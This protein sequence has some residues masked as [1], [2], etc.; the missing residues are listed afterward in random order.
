[1]KQTHFKIF[2]RNFFRAAFYMK[3]RIRKHKTD[4][5]DL[6]SDNYFYLRILSDWIWLNFIPIIPLIFITTKG[7]N[8]HSSFNRSQPRLQSHLSVDYQ[9]TSYVSNLNLKV[10][11]NKVH[12]EHIDVIFGYWWVSLTENFAEFQSKI[13]YIAQVPMQC[14]LPPINHFIGQV[15]V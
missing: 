2:I 15:L 10:K 13:N 8:A 4:Q 11:L 1:M 3:F 12:N 9:Q 6:I 7:G 14:T 5:Y